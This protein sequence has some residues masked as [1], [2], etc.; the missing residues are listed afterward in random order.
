M[1]LLSPLFSIPSMMECLKRGMV[2]ELFLLVIKSNN[3][4]IDRLKYH[5]IMKELMKYSMSLRSY[6]PVCVDMAN[7]LPCHCK[8]R[9]QT[10]SLYPKTKIVQS[11]EDIIICISMQKLPPKDGYY[12][13]FGSAK[14]DVVMIGV[15]EPKFDEP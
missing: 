15:S 1:S 7:S 13:S 3:T 8:P 6:G 2:M 14:I 4:L 5:M 10:L 11:I 9:Q 12:C